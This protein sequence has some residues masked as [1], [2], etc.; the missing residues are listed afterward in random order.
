M[1]SLK[2]KK[3][4]TVKVLTGKYR[5]KT[6]KVVRVIPALNKIVVE[7]VNLVTKHVRSRNAGA[8]GQRVQFP[9]P[10]LIAKVM[11][12]CPKCGVATRV[13]YEVTPEKK[14]RQCKRCQS[15]I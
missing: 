1:S 12:V 15:Q 13:G 10:M 2:I 3:G 9:A 8:P 14:Y 5:G 7:G 6:G 11:L 4:D